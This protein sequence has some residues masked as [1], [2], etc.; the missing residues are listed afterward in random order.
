MHQK[1]PK[2]EPLGLVFKAVTIPINPCANIRAENATLTGLPVGNEV[3]QRQYW[4]AIHK[5][6]FHRRSPK[7]SDLR[8]TH[9][10]YLRADLRVATKTFG[11]AQLMDNELPPDILRVDRR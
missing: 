1:K 11:G 5:S 2:R 10:Q 7:V 6:A 4:R 3:Q 9:V 8:C